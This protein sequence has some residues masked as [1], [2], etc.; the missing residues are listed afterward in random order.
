ME[1]KYFVPS[2][3]GVILDLS[4]LPTDIADPRP[5]CAVVTNNQNLDV[6]NFYEVHDLELGALEVRVW[7]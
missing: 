5:V 6:D 2:S 7:E 1:R 4:Q 3:E